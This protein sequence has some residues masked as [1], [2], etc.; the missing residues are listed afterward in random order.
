MTAPTMAA[1]HGLPVTEAH[2]RWCRKHG[3]ATWTVNGKPQGTCAR[4]GEVSA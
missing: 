1:A 2:A 3:H 4:C